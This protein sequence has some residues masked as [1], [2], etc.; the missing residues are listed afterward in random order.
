MRYGTLRVSTGMVIGNRAS[1]RLTLT[2]PDLS[3]WLS[4]L[5]PEEAVLW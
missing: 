1:A 3:D 2:A 4:S 5:K